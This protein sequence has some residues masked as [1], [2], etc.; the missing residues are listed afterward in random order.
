MRGK[1]QVDFIDPKILQGLANG[2]DALARAAFDAAPDGV[3]VVD[4]DGGILC[5]NQRF[6][7]L[8]KFP[9]D[10][11]ARREAD[12]MRRHTA[13]QLVDSQGVNLSAMSH[14]WVPSQ[15]CRAPREASSCGGAMSRCATA[16]SSASAN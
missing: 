9:P 12:E 2:D 10:M 5:F 15:G 7:D 13:A 14:R 16:P 4:R 1:W 11:L 8:W 6:V 3:V